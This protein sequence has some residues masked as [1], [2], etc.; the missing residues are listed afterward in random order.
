MIVDASVWIDWLRRGEGPAAQ[1]L[2]LALRLR[3]VVLLPVILQEI[4]QGAANSDRFQAWQRA[5]SVLPMATTAD[6]TAT[7]IHAAAL[8]ARSRWA[9]FTIR[10]ASDCLIA[11]SC[12]E[13]DLP[14]LHQDGD[15]VRIASIEP[16]L[17]LVVI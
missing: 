6:A 11:A 4:L 3:E 12:I 13:L 17:L 2:D 14:L 5:L 1:R 9:G 8:Y 7:A 15:F 16:A 10:S